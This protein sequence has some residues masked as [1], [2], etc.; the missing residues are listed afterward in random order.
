MPGRYGC[1]VEE[2]KVLNRP[3]RPDGFTLIELLTVIG[4]IVLVLA[5]ALPNFV[6]MMRGRRWS[7]AITNI[8]TMIMRARSLA[9]NVRKDFSVEFEIDGDNGTVMWLESEANDIERIPDLW[10]LQH[11]LG[12]HEPIDDF[13]TGAF[14]DSGGRYKC[15]ATECSCV[16]PGCGH[17]WTVYSGGGGSTTVCPKCH[18]DWWRYRP[19]KETYYYDIEYH[20]ELTKRLEYG[21]NA[22]QS[23][24]VPLGHQMT[25]DLARS[26]YF[27]SWDHPDSVECYGGDLYPDI[28]IGTNG[29]L[30]QTVDPVICL[31]DRDAEERRAVTAV[32]CTGRVIPTRVP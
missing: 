27:M 4:I 24:W 12:G 16:W 31:M 8:Q 14:Y 2:P 18:V 20:P 13:V 9:T 17:Q 1:F 28:R 30:V 22:R 29:A 5:L 23:E 32:R 25:I 6:S 26:R 7:A 10:E 3:R 21:D 19:Q 11:E 15:W